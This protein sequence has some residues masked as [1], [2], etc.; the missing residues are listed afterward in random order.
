MVMHRNVS[1]FPSLANK[2]INLLG[3]YVHSFFKNE[4]IALIQEMA[5]APWKQ[6]EYSKLTTEIILQVRVI[7]SAFSCLPEGWVQENEAVEEADP[8]DFKKRTA[9]ARRF[10]ELPTADITIIADMNLDELLASS[11]PV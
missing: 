5:A 3:N 11:T 7:L 1:S 2:C 9:I 4:T 8:M 6:E 10:V